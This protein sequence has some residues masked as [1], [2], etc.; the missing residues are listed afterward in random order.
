MTTTQVERQMAYYKR[1]RAKGF[2]RVCVEVPESNVKELKQL[3]TEW[4]RKH[5]EDLRK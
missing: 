1:Q 4:R 3:A 2:K 5:L